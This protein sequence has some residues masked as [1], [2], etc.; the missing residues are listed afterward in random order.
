MTDADKLK[1]KLG[2]PPVNQI[3]VVVKDM[4]KAIEYYS[5][6]FGIGTFT[7]YEF[8]P[9]KHWFMEEASYLKILMGKAQWGDIEW[10]LLQPIEGKSL[11]KEF[12]ETNGEGLHH[13]G[14]NI[15][16]YDE[17]FDKF[18]EAGFKPVMRAE[19]YVETYKGFLK[20]CYF[21]TRRVGGVLFEII[22]KSWLMESEK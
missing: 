1:V 15:R 12:L 18:L 5:S 8:V 13:L 22:W 10:E 19:S 2:L 17:M 9:E 14:F 7:V 3:G 4:N 21:D 11:H 16:N 6:L 20:A